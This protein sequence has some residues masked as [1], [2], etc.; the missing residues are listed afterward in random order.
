MILDD[1]DRK[2]IAAL[3]T[4]A[5]LSV[6]ELARQLDVS[7]TTVQDRMQRLED[8]GVIAGY[9]VRL[10]SAL[11]RQRVKALILME[12]APR[13]QDQVVAALRRMDDASVVYTIAGEFDLAAM[14]TADDTETLDE[15][16]DR[17]AKHQA[18]VRTQTSILLSTKFERPA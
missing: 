17:I 2:L 6:S 9:G 5:R 15:T 16:I 7:R 8:R 4:N 14:V 13:T 18:V 3:K 10:G 12:L 1:L 11:E